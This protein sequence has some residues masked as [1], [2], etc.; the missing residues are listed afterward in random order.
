MS[1]KLTFAYLLKMTDPKKFEKMSPL[2]QAVMEEHFERLKEATNE[3]RLIFAGP[4]LDGA[5]GI[6]VFNARSRKEAE[7]FMR[8]DP[9]VKH[10]IMTAELHTFRVSLIQKS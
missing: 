5:F 7:E 10:G 3:G 8:Q 9:A 6:V 4:C 1:Q 2:E